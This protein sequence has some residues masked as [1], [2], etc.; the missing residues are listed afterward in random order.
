MPTLTEII[1]D[2]KKRHAVVDDGVIVI[3]QEVADKGGL[4]GM[5]IKAAFGTVKKIK[6]G[7]IGGS[8]NHLLDDFAAQVDPFWLK[9]Q[10]EKAD[11]RGYF[12]KNGNAIANALLKITDDR[13]KK[14][15]GAARSAYDQLR[16]KAVEHVVTAMPRLAELVKKH[17]S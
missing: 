10:E 14:A 15:S 6:P 2:P 3:E 17:A 7:F 5:A 16:P 1:K 9:C 13:S 8:L 4:S 11:A 12:V